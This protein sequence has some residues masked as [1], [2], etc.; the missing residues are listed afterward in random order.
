MTAS[1]FRASVIMLLV[2]AVV[3]GCAIASVEEADPARIPDGPL[4]A[5]GADATGPIVEL[6]RGR[7]LGIGWRYAVYASGEGW[8][9]QLELTSF[10][11]SGCGDLV[12]PEGSAFGSVSTN[13]APSEM[14]T[15]ADGIVSADVAEVWLETSTGQRIRA[16]LMPLAEAGLEGSAFIGFAPA[17]SIV[18][19]ATAIGADGQE[20]ETFDLP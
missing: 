1:P 7:S 14:V 5:Q 16:M 8:C 13:G 3:G 10:S 20:L 19:T 4:Q 6:G 18:R 15:P 9:T 2:G 11:S 12:P 17:G